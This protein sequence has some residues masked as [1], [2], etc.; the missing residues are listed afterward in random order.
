[1]ES[2]APS[3]QVMPE[4]QAQPC[5][6]TTKPVAVAAPQLRFG[7]EAEQVNKPTNSAKGLTIKNILVQCYNGKWLKQSDWRW[8]S[9]LELPLTIDSKNHSVARYALELCHFV[10][11]DN[12]DR[13][14]NYNLMI[15]KR[16]WGI[17]LQVFNKKHSG[18]C[19]S[20]KVSTLMW[21]NNSTRRRGVRGRNRPLQG[22]GHVLEFIWNNLN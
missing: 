3:L 18:R 5:H 21:K 7:A 14:L 19:G 16:Q 1:M 12:E 11:D 17:Q 9:K 15:V 10:M 2:A 4:L 22:W 20:Y 8:S 6:Q 13:H